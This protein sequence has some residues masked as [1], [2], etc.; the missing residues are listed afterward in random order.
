MKNK[1]FITPEILIYLGIIVIA[2]IIILMISP[3]KIKVIDGC[4]YIQTFNG[5]GG[6]TLTHKGNCTNRIHYTK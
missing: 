3:N 6:W 2:V 1:A 5:Q 4:Q